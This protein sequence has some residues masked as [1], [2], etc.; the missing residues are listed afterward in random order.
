MRHKL[1]ILCALFVFIS[2]YFV[3]PFAFVYIPNSYKYVHVLYV[4]N[5]VVNCFCCCCCDCCRWWSPALALVIKRN[6]ICCVVVDVAHSGHVLWNV[7]QTN[8]TSML[9]N[10]VATTTT[11]TRAPQI[12]TTWKAISKNV[13]ISL[14]QRKQVQER[15]SE[16][17]KTDQA[18]DKYDT[19]ITKT[20]TTIVT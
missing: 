20:V 7:K 12:P 4:H 19:T 15:T 10:N 9:D 5:I 8:G 17:E 3:A 2:T 6:K 14:S 16:G 18:W 11:T 1:T 13:A